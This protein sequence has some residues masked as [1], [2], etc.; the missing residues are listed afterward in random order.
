MVDKSPYTMMKFS[1]FENIVD[2]IYKYVI[3][4]AKSSATKDC[5]LE[6]VLLMAILLGYS[7]LLAHT[8]SHTLLITWCHSS[9]M[10]I[11]DVSTKLPRLLLITLCIVFQDMNKASLFVLSWLVPLLGQ[12]GAST[13]HE[14]YSGL[15]LVAAVMLLQNKLDR[16]QN[17]FISSWFIIFFRSHM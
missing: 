3:P 10:P 15:L 14:L 5:S 13:M 17:N 12:N 2:A 1:T 4:A 9:T 16:K 7:V 11:D 6:L 8:L